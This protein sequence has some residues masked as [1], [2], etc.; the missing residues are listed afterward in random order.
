MML[1]YGATSVEEQLR[2]AFSLI[3]RDNSG[4]ISSDE[5]KKLMRSLG[6]ALSDQDI[7]DLVREVDMV[8]SKTKC[9]FNVYKLTKP[10]R[11]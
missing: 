11:V 9:F 10:Y 2:D 1:K 4:K 3:D 7:A 6:E 8:I 5:L